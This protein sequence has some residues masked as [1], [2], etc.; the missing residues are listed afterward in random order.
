MI[1]FDRLP[2]FRKEPP[3]PPPPPSLGERLRDAIER[4]PYL[5]QIR[6]FWSDLQAER[7]WWPVLLPFL[8]WVGWRAYRGEQRTI[9]L[10]RAAASRDD[11]S[12]AADATSMTG[13]DGANDA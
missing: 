3:P 13:W 7:R 1:I 11:R 4:I 9:A 6:A 12:D 2:F 5:P 8:A 10:E